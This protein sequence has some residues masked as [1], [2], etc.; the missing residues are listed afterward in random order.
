M[1]EPQVMYE[2]ILENE[3]ERLGVGG[4]ST[5]KVDRSHQPSTR[6]PTA[7]NHF[8][9]GIWPLKPDRRYS[10]SNQS[11]SSQSSS[12]SREPYPLI[13][14]D[15]SNYSKPGDSLL[16]PASSDSLF[17][18]GDT[19]VPEYNPHQSDTYPIVTSKDYDASQQDREPT[20]APSVVPYASNFEF[21]GGRMEDQA[22]ISS[23][24]RFTSN[25]EQYYPPLEFNHFAK[26]I[27]PQPVSSNSMNY[28]PPRPPQPIV[29]D[30]PIAPA[31]SYY[32]GG[33]KRV[34]STAVLPIFQ[35]GA[36]LNLISNI[37]FA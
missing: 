8:S 27:I 29:A 13:S 7:D 26:K 19:E 32:S 9:D 10:E 36:N 4:G 25:Q 35:I 3:T 28:I 34:V 37:T 33:V 17:D 15:Y 6:E 23:A 21:G 22:E 2:N 16:R 18:C 11:S 31:S 14:T 5:E 30:N 12:Q 24:A 1:R 20:A